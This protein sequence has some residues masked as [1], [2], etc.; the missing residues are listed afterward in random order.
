MFFAHAHTHIFPHCLNF[1][2]FRKIFHDFYVYLLIF[3]PSCACA[4][5]FSPFHIFMLFNFIFRCCASFARSSGILLVRTAG[6]ESVKEQNAPTHCFNFS[7]GARLYVVRGLL[8][9]TVSLL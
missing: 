7:G 1:D 8:V 9:C 5:F 6:A 4:V 3:V 2:F